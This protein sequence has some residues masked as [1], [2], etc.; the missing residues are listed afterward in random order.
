MIKSKDLFGVNE[1]A[2]K[3]INKLSQ[4]CTICHVS[5]LE[6]MDSWKWAMPLEVFLM[7]VGEQNWLLSNQLKPLTPF[8]SFWPTNTPMNNSSEKE[9]R[10][11]RYEGVLQNI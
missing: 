5:S 10:K 1:Q 2:H 6:F 9:L 7:K 3:V 4:K 8:R 11:Y